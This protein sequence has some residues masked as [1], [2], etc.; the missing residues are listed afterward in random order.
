MNGQDDNTTL[1]KT[2]K[3]LVLLNRLQQRPVPENPVTDH[4]GHI[5]S[6]RSFR[7]SHDDVPARMPSQSWAGIATDKSRWGISEEPSPTIGRG[8]TDATL[9]AVLG[10]Q[11]E[12]VAGQRQLRCAC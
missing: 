1:S 9:A 7:R 12:V 8:D 2:D 11:K 10:D 3:V 5:Q 6:F 4:G